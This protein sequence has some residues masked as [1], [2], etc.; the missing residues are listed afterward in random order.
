MGP[1]AGDATG[2]GGTLTSMGK[3]EDED[4]YEKHRRLKTEFHQAYNDYDDAWHKIFGWKTGEAE[5]AK[6]SSNHPEHW[7]LYH[8]AA[9]RMGAAS[10]RLAD[11]EASMTGGPVFSI[12]SRI[13]RDATNQSLHRCPGCRVNMAKA[14]KP[15][16]NTKVEGAQPLVWHDLATHEVGGPGVKDDFIVGHGAYNIY[17]HMGKHLLTYTELPVSHG[18][19]LSDEAYRQHHRSR[20][21]GI[22]ASREDARTAAAHHHIIQHY[23]LKPHEVKAAK[24]AWPEGVR[25]FEGKHPDMVRADLDRAI[26]AMSKAEKPPENTK[27][28]GAKKDA[29]K[30][31]PFGKDQPSVKDGGEDQSIMDAKVEGALVNA[32]FEHVTGKLSPQAIGLRFL[33]YHLKRHQNAKNKA[34][35]TRKPLSDKEEKPD[36]SKKTIV[37]ARVDEGLTPDQK[38]E[39]RERR[40]NRSSL[41][42][43]RERVYEGKAYSVMTGWPEEHGEEA[44]GF[45][46]GTT[47]GVPVD[48]LSLRRPEPSRSRYRRYALSVIEPKLPGGKTSADQGGIP[49]ERIRHDASSSRGCQRRRAGLNVEDH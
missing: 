14:E 26:G 29:Q 22:H 42:P 8:R 3:S 38:I 21:L 40:Q 49:G 12:R 2:D 43:G 44:K 36:P 30:R 33:A 4:P 18:G 32:G 46:P 1:V 11:H 15:P 23:Q 16:E 20:D 48:P 35:F 45:A 5:H 24:K 9:E 41:D 34:D 31:A 39:A 27:E 25:R 13:R 7:E 6:E 47:Q 10:N 37:K 17:P 19:R 28:A